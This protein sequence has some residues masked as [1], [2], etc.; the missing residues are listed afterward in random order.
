VR[1]IG[2]P[3][4]RRPSG[5]FR[6]GGFDGLESAPNRRHKKSDQRDFEVCFREIPPRKQD[7]GAI[8]FSAGVGHAVREIE[9]GVT[10]SSL[11]ELL[12]RRDSDYADLVGD[13]M[14]VTPASSRNASTCFC[15]RRGAMSSRVERTMRTSSRTNGDEGR[16]FEAAMASY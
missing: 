9:F 14:T 7:R 6:C 8:A 4:V 5:G 1:K 2:G 10:A 16:C 3:Y 12:E 15:A 11:A 13:G